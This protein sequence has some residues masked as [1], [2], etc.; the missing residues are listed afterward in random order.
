MRRPQCCHTLHQIPSKSVYILIFFLRKSTTFCCGMLI[1]SQVWCKAETLR[2][3]PILESIIFHLK[4]RFHFSTSLKLFFKRLVGIFYALFA[5]VIPLRI[6]FKI[7]TF[8]F[9]NLLPIEIRLLQ[10]QMIFKWQSCGSFL[11]SHFA[12]LRKCFRVQTKWV[13][14]GKKK[15]T[16]HFYALSRADI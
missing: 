15:S 6:E 13:T 14:Q 11:S 9:S 4:S 3:F 2:R 7:L 8:L 1:I 5:K 10:K 16:S 12:F